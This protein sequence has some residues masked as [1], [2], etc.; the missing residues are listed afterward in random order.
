MH[1][2]RRRKMLTIVFSLLLLACVV[3]LILFALRQ[4]IHLFYTPSSLIEAHVSQKQVIRLG[5]MVVPGSVVR[6]EG[7]AVNFDVTDFK[8]NVSIQYTGVL[9][10]LFRE[11]KGVVVQGYWVN[12]GYFHAVTVLAKHD[13][14]YMPKNL[15]Q[16]MERQ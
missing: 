8:K 1:P 3:G 2:R 7:L 10:D 4:N 6:G 16:A 9:P 11:N 12:T 5:G 14:N 13:E 15:Q